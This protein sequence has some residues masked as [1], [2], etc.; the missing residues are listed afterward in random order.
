ML[1]KEFAERMGAQP[2]GR[3]YGVLSISCQL[4]S[5]ITLGPIVPGNSFHPPTKVQSRVLEM[6][7]LSEPRVPI[8]DIDWLK[9][10]V[11]GAFLQRRKKI[12]N[13]LK[14]SCIRSGTQIME[15][16]EKA[17]IDPN[18]RAETLSMSEFALLAESLKHVASDIPN[19][20]LT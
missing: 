2:G 19:E 11:K 6:K 8:A 16:L 17:S 14:A 15:A 13:S 1:Q 18:R 9:K 20:P 10:V 4:F 5:D 12:H 3:D 7:F